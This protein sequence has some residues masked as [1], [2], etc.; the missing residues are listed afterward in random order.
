METIARYCDL[1]SWTGECVFKGVELSGD[2]PLTI[3]TIVLLLC[4]ALVVFFLYSWVQLQRSSITFQRR[5]RALINCLERERTS[6]AHFSRAA[7][8][9]VG[10]V[11]GKDAL[12]AHGWKEFTETLVVDASEGEESIYNTRQAEGFF[13]HDEIVSEC[14]HPAFFQAVPGILTSLGLLGTFLAILLGLAAIS[15]PED[16]SKAVPSSEPTAIAAQQATE[17]APPGSDTN[18]QIEGIGEFVNALSGKF[19]SSVLALLCAIG[20][21]LVETRALRKAEQT[22]RNFCQTFDSVFPRRTAEELLMSMV[23]GIRDQSAAFQHF[24]TD[25]SVRFRDGVSEGLG[26]VLERIS[27]G[28]QSLTGERDQNIEAL[29]ERLTGEFRSAMTKSA[30]VELGQVASTMEQASELIR[31]GNE[32]TEQTR[33]SLTRLVTAMEDSSSRQLEIS[34]NQ[35]QTMQGLLEKMVDGV[36]R[37]STESQS[38][39][40]ETVRSLLERTRLES[41]QAARALQSNISEHSDQMRQQISALMERVEAASSKMENAG[42]ESGR[43]LTESIQRVSEMLKDSVATVAGQMA[44][45]ASG[46][47]QSAGSASRQVTEELREVLEQHRSSVKSVADTEAALERTL[48]AWN[49]GMKQMTG[50]VESIRQSAELISTTSSNLRAASGAIGQ[51]QEQLASIFSGAQSEIVRLQEMGVTSQELLNEYHKVFHDVQA[52]LGGILST[53]TEKL[54][55]L[56]DVS[57]SG[58]TAQLQEFDN[59]LGS[60]TRKLGSAVD[61]LS[62]VLDGM[63]DRVVVRDD[64]L[65]QQA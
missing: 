31:K 30:G 40:D 19:A 56:Q 42:V 64:G 10:E 54:Q 16:T 7:L 53:I 65:P 63:V 48:E 17:P 60:A 18:Q 51:A 29:M 15:V 62:D 8:N 9:R 20:F 21:T 50:V 11:I 2:K 23:V 43:E 47:A 14:M 32:Q 52:G 59:H 1:T 38:A 24:N 28:L 41:E 37:A 58:L 27:D 45:A 57:A 39:L 61:E 6:G 3:P 33:D 55:V 34:N 49:Q 22:Y 44:Q 26:P 4:I 46:V 5:F 25:L 12:C 36:G 35:A 13:S